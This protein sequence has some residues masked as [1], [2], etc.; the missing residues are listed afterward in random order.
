MKRSL[1]LSGLL[2]AGIYAHGQTLFEEHFNNYTLVGNSSAIGNYTTWSLNAACTDSNYYNWATPTPLGET[3]YKC[4]SF[5]VTK[6][7]KGTDTAAM[8]AGRLVNG[9]GVDRWLLLPPLTITGAN[10]FLRWKAK[11]LMDG[12][13]SYKIMVATSNTANP[14][15]ANFSALYSSGFQLLGGNEFTEFSIPLGA[16]AG[17]TIRLAFRYGDGGM[18]GNHVMILDDVVVDNAVSGL[19]ASLSAGGTD[20]YIPMTQ[21]SLSFMLT[22]KK[23]TPIGSV[24]V[25]IQVD[26]GSVQTQTVTPA[27]PVNFGST[28]KLTLG[29]PVSMPSAGTRN[30]KIFIKTLNGVPSAS[31]ADDTATWGQYVYQYKPVHRSL[32]EDLTGAWCHACPSMSYA[33]DELMAEVKNDTGIVVSHHYNDAMAISIASTLAGT[34]DVGSYPSALFNRTPRSPYYPDYE[35]Y[36]VAVSSEP[37]P[38]ELRGVA[39]EFTPVD[40]SIANNTF[41]AN[42]RELSFRVDAKFVTDDDGPYNINAFLVEDSITGSGTGY[43]QVNGQ[44]NTPGAPFYNQGNPIIDFHHKNVVFAAL[45]NAWGN[46]IVIPVQQTAG[47]TYS[48]QYT[49]TIPVALSGSLGRYNPARI[50]IVALVQKGGTAIP[51][52]YIVNAVKKSIL[53]PNGVNGP[54]A[55]IVEMGV[56]P[57][58][59]HDVVQVSIDMRSGGEVKIRL[60]NQLGQI[61]KSQTF[62]QQGG[63]QQRTIDL[64]GLT[65][66]VYFVEAESEGY[67]IVRKLVVE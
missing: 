31:P 63:V 64:K 43:D 8:V 60:T 42:T 22:N 53:A 33:L 25:G 51:D 35:E 52:K 24:E 36:D 19:D 61:V 67:K 14:T 23:A 11:G 46:G 48:K 27:G 38:Y 37:G 54:V 65:A 45:D 44:N 30:I 55:S 34:Y 13:E 50:K 5:M 9:T 62:L 41:N 15:S 56:F 47:Q 16:Y 39:G 29:N 4:G 1:L 12:Y 7:M 2:A 18:S 3:A 59:A 26:N 17:Q 20:H 49:F 32:I 21:G 28:Q 57:N 6:V 58:P 40:I 10:T 66:G